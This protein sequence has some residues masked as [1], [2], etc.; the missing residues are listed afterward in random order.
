[1]K[2][3]KTNLYNQITFSNL[4]GQ[5]KILKTNCKNKRKLF[6]FAK[7]LNSNIL[8]TGTKL[9]NR[10]Y[11]FSDYNIFLIHEN[12]FRIIMSECISD[13]L[14]S[15]FI[16]NY[17]LQNSLES[18]LILQNVATRKGLGSKAAYDFF[19]RYL[20]KFDF[21]QKIYVLKIDISKYFYSISH[22][23]LKKKMNFL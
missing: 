8:D 1:M 16:S 12:K 19:N 23:I 11:S 20:H 17:C 4:L 9:R 14:V 21:N 7:E 22:E 13:K 18:K 5:Y 6:Y 3:I 2:R 10:C 15:H